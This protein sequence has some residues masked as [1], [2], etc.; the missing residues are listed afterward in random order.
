[1]FEQI[2]ET[3]DEWIVSRTGI[4]ERRIEQEKYNYEMIGEACKRAL[5][6]AGI[7]ADKIDMIIVSTVTQDY[8]YPS[9]ACLVQNYIKAG[10]AV[11]FDISAACAGFV[12]GLDI[13]DAYIKSGK[14][15]NILVASG[16]LMSRETDY[17]D[18]SNCILFGDGAGAAV[19]SAC[20]YDDVGR[21]DPGAPLPG[22]L[23][24]YIAGECDGEKPLF[25]KSQLYKPNEIFDKN[26]KRFKGNAVKQ[27]N[28]LWQNGREVLKFVSRIVPIALDE[29]L[30]RAGKNI[31][32]LKY[33]I[34]HQANKRIIDHVIE[35]YNLDPEKVPINIDKYGNMSSCT[36]PVLLHELNMAGKLK[37]GDL[38]ALAGF[39]SGLVYGAAVIR[40]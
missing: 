20:G 23:A 38:I 19:V 11:S 22:I 30:K 16:D 10:N 8:N 17:S 21:D 33:I 6:N 29:V 34:L 35:K 15:K 37:K 9:A 3:S 2:I 1:M 7:S 28:Y 18:R 12:F 36:V 14:A 26:T 13:A 24:S 32:D 5:E 31:S 4:K 27:Q 25:I 39:G 40:W